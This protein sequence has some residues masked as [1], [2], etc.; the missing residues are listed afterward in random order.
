MSIR[1]RQISLSHVFQYPHGPLNLI[2]RIPLGCVWYADGT[3][4]DRMGQNRTGVQCLV[5]HCRTRQDR[6]KPVKM[7]NLPLCQNQLPKSINP[8]PKLII[9][10]IHKSGTKIKIRNQSISKNYEAQ[11]ISRNQKSWRKKSEILISRN[12]K[13]E[14]M[15]H[16]RLAKITD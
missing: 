4:Q 11:S 2:Q 1:Q 9:K 10:S 16:N 12:K 5:R 13:S 14:I 15:K 6:T 3:G 7:T 8:E